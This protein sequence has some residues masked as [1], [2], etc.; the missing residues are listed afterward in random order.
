LSRHIWLEIA[1]RRVPGEVEP[2]R[3][4]PDRGAAAVQYLRFKIPDAEAF[5]RGP[6]ALIVDHPAYAHRADFSRATI[7][8]L[9][10]DLA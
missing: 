4:A 2:G 7:D 10:K 5:A 9:A 6:A 3:E 8:S 1:G